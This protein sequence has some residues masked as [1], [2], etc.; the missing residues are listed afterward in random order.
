MS[1][2]GVSSTATAPQSPEEARA[3]FRSGTSGPTAG[4]AAGH[5]LS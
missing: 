1:P 3:L 4:W 2:T 5:T